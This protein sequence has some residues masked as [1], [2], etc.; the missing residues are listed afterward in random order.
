VALPFLVNAENRTK[1]LVVLIPLMLYI[2]FMDAGA[3][4]FQSLGEFGTHFHYN[5]S[6]TVLIRYL[7]GGHYVFVSICLLGTCLVWMYLF[8]HNELRS[9]YLALGCLLVFLP[10]LHPWYLVLIAPFLV[11]FPSR[12]W[13]YLQAAVIFIFPIS[14]IEF[15]TGVFQEISWLKLFE[16]VPFYGL[17]FDGLFRGG[18]LLRDKSYPKPTCISAVIPALNESGSLIRCLESLQNRTALNEI[19]VADGGS[20]DGTPA[21]ATRLGARVV[22]SPKG[23]GLQIRKGVES[24]SGGVIV[25]LH[26]DCAVKKGVFKRILKK[27]ESDPDTVGGAVGMQFER[28][29]PKTIV[30]AF[31]NNL[32]TFLTGISFGDQAQFF[33]T[34]ALAASGGFPSMML[35]EDVELSLR[36]KEVGR[37]V[38]LRK[39]ILVSGRR[40]FDNGF[41]GN[42][43]TVFH[44]FPRY[45]I[46]RRFFRRDTLK[47]NYYDIYYSDRKGLSRN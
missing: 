31:L 3:D 11:F 14:A 45:L 2:P 12:A 37:L 47:R 38:F 36:L 6:M 7:F 29:N 21:L 39:G 24:A 1:S 20:I 18:F 4:I 44:L 27:L 10:T 23:R 28:N 22:E 17:L 9:V 41:T 19:I 15:N 25:I 33:R 5:D 42:L 26:A 16:Y 34:E 32:R 30:I 13:L 35:M 46:E 40:W 8:V 43:M